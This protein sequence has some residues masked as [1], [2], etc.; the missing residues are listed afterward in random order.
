VRDCGH[1]RDKPERKE[2]TAMATEIAEKR[3]I[4]RMIT[5]SS[6][7]FSLMIV[8]VASLLSVMA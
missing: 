7:T 1:S 5:L 2:V 3:R 6:V 8:L 4:A